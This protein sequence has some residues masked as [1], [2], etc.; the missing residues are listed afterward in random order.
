MPDILLIQPPIRDFYLTAKRTLPYGLASIAASLRGAGFTVAICDGLA[1]TRSRA[2]PW[3]EEMDF[4]LPYY[5][6]SDRSPFGLFHQFRH[7]GYS[8]EY[9]AGQARHSGAFLIGI[10][11]L[12]SAYSDMAL[13]T[14]AAVRNACPDACIVLGGHHPTALPEAVM[15][16]PSVDMVL[17]GDGEMTMP[18]LAR[19][20]KEGTDLGAVPGLV[21]RRSDGALAVKPPA[22]VEDLDRLPVP[23]LDLIQWRHYQRS[24]TGS[25]SLAASRGCPLRCTYCAVNTASHHG[26]RRRTVAS[27]MAELSAA[28]S[29]RPMGFIDFEDEHLCADKQWVTDLM[30]Q[31]AGRFG[32]WRPELRAMNGLF[33]P[34]LDA[35]IVRWMR[36][37]GFKTLNLALITTSV[38]QLKR[39]ARP[40][41][42][43]DLDRVLSIARGLGMTAV[44]YV[45][46]AGPGQAPLDSVADLLFLARRRVIAGVSVFYPAPG[47]GDFQWCRRQNILPPTLGLIR[48][49]ALPLVQSSDRRQTVTLLRLGRILNFMKNLLDRDHRLPAP[50][51]PPRRI[52]PRTDR[53]TIGRVLLAAFL[54]DGLIYGTDADGR[55]YAHCID[56][57]LTRAFIKGVRHVRLPGC[58]P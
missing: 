38:S 7:F 58:G 40:D 12:F 42:T 15:D 20:L 27:V 35:D 14:A 34:A 36:S 51:K 8:L 10:S 46:I 52:D 48:A 19:A 21:R 25:L 45:I 55:L 4:L 31:I 29:I 57:A 24:G 11:S 23:A 43:C 37:A 17:R 2:I 6:R 5:G 53:M 32:R 28:F 1:T 41:T 13:S 16:H 33:A 50:A 39:F 30:R 47:S 49:T 26:Y 9:I 54:R 3:P 18:L 44:V 56:P 22:V